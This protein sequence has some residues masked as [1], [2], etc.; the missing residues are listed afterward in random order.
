M[1]LLEFF[2][3]L[4]PYIVQVIRNL[5]CHLDRLIRQSFFLDN[6]VH[7]RTRIQFPFLIPLSLCHALPF[8][9]IDSKTQ[10]IIYR[11]RS[12]AAV[13]ICRPPSRDLSYVILKRNNYIWLLLRVT[14]CILSPPAIWRAWPSLSP[15]FT[16]SSNFCACYASDQYWEINLST[17]TCCMISELYE[18]KKKKKRKTKLK[19]RVC[20]KTHPILPFLS[21]IK[22]IPAV[23]YN[24]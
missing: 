7:S 15:P 4:L 17:G 16:L 11:G 3:N 5:W 19:E 6:P 2:R 13:W 21:D 24:N 12:N 22:F 1:G 9:I 18:I 8:P 14:V 10:L 23:V 20:P